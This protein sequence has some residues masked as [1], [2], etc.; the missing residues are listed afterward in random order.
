MQRET[1]GVSPYLNMTCRALSLLLIISIF[2]NAYADDKSQKAKVKAISEKEEKLSDLD[3]KIKGEKEELKKAEKEESKTLKQLDD[4]NKE[5]SKNKNKLNSLN[6]KLKNLKK[7]AV[8][9]EGQIKELT[10]DIA[11]QKKLFNQR[12]IAL[13]RYQRSGGMLR[14]VFSSN[15]YLDLSRRTKFIVMVLDQD[16][17]TISTFLEQISS[18]E[19]KKI[20]LQENCK[21]LEDTKERIT[22][23]KKQVAKKKE[24]QS[25]LLQKIQ[26]EKELHRANL[27]KLEKEARELQ[28]LIDSLGKEEEKKKPPSSPVKSTGFAKLKGK[29]PLPV[30]GKILS[31]YGKKVDPTL[32]TT[33]FQKGIE[34]AADKGDEVRAIYQGKVLYAQSF[35]G[36]GKIIIVDHGDSYYS[37]SGYLSKI[38][39]SPGDRVEAGEVIALSG[40][41][42]SLKGPRL[43]FELRHQGKTVD[44]L[45]WL[46]SP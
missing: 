20:A 13:Y 30:Q 21:S 5:L 7:K 23:K 6:G 9:I 46:R 38:L 18:I 33:F 2:T 15:S 14:T 17:Q 26:E 44:P 35:K 31:R 10:R 11:K 41:T 28:S 12:L 43:Y 27:E 32:N 42:G 40:E 24:A 45:P 4:I 34:I 3:K 36:Y 1:T 39:K 19:E 16:R 25:E 8:D 37:L 29:L 22:D